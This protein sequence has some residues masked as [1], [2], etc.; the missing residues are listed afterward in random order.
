LAKK[1]KKMKKWRFWGVDCC[2]NAVFE[3]KTVILGEKR[4]FL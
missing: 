3:R 2:E 1:Q 4:W